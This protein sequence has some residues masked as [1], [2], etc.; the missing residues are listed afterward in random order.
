[1]KNNVIKTFGVLILALVLMLTFIP[2][3]R[4]ET[5]TISDNCVD[6]VARFEGCRLNAYKCPAG[7]W[8][9]GYG[10]TTGVKQG[11]TLAN[12]AEAKELLREDLAKYAN[13]VNNCIGNGT[14]SFEM[15]QNRFDALVS[16]TFNCGSG[17]LE[18][19]VKGKTAETVAQRILTY[20]RGGGKI[21]PSLT[22]RREAE[23]DLFLM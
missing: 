8:T 10:H 22:K 15:N 5:Y 2:E 18:K 14:I 4:A 19:L 23:R 6:L 12:E 3:V 7:V 17:N 11:M 16:F 21:L 1:M 9:I 13:S 20:N